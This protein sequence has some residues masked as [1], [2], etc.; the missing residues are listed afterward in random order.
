MASLPQSIGKYRILKE[1]ARG[2]F[3]RVYRGEDTSKQN[4]PVAVKF[5]H[6]SHLASPQE[7]SSFLQEAQLLTLLRHPYIVPVLDV[8]IEEEIP[9]LVMEYAPL[10]SLYN[11]LKELAP[12]PLPVKDALTMLGQVG[13]ALQYAHQQ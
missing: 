7:R 6:A 12:R 3:G 11:R 2:S 8:G 4:H 1:I 10:G 13:T 5:M 9:Y